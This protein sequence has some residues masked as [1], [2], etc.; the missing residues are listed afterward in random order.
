MEKVIIVGG[1]IGGLGTAVAL[2]QAGIPVTVYEQ[3]EAIGQVGA[4]LTLWSNALRVLRRLGLAEAVIEAGAVIEEAQIRQ[5]NGRILSRSYPGQLAQQLGEPTVAIHRADLHRILLAALPRDVVQL[6]AACTG[7]S[8]DEQ[9][10]TVTFADGRSAQADCLIGADGLNS[11]IRQQIAPQ[12]KTRYAGYIAWRGVVATENR[13]ARGQTFEAWGQGARFGVVPLSNQLVYWFA[14]ANS[15]PGQRQEPNSQKETLLRQFKGWHDPI[16]HLLQTTPAEAILHHDLYDVPPFTGWSQGRV[17][18]LGDAAHPTTPNMGQGA[19]MAI[20]SAYILANCLKEH[21]SLAE[22]LPAY[23]AQRQPRTA[24]I[25]QQ[26]WQI[27]RIA[28]WQNRFACWLRDGLL[29]AAPNHLLQK[30]LVQT[31]NFMF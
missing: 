25:T 5:A 18:L 19:C 3:A 13:V 15:S 24:V 16:P 27:G 17:T 21:A 31:T 14:T 29:N 1:G 9:Q 10:V 20:E 4:G 23:E 6:G 11:V 2:H 22:A 26:S 30:R 28:Q 7:V 12:A 8:Q